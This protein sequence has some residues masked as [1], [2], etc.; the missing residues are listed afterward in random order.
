MKV[1]P[2]ELVKK[3]LLSEEDRAN[4]EEDCETGDY[5][6]QVAAQYSIGHDDAVRAIIKL[7]K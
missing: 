1:I 6:D 7:A 5:D 2:L 3:L 4:F